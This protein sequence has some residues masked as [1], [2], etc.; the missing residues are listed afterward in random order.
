MSRMIDLIKQSKMPANMV[1]S[2]AKGALSVAP[3]EMIEILVYLAANPVF[4]Q[5]ARM[6]LAGW[7]EKT[8]KYVLED[9]R[10]PPDVLAYFSAPENIRLPLLSSLLDNPSLKDDLIVGLAMQASTRVLANMLWHPRVLSNKTTLHAISMNVNLPEEDAVVVRSALAN[11]GEDTDYLIEQARL[12]EE[13]AE[14]KIGDDVLDAELQRYTRE[15]ADEIAAEE[16][17]GKVFELYVEGTVPSLDFEAPAPAG[18]VLSGAGQVPSLVQKAVDAPPLAPDG[19]PDPSI[20]KK[21]T[22]FQKIA[23]LGV[24]GR[25]QLA[26][27]GSKDERFILVRD[28]SKVVSSAVLES[29]KI[30]DQEIEM[31]ATLKN[32]QEAVLRGISSKRKFM[33][34]YVVQKNLANNPRAPLD[35]TL[36]ILKGLMINDLRSMAGNKNINDTLRKMALKLYKQRTEKKQE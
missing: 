36:P 20:L 6:T 2:A 26:M 10:C 35:V 9:P 33:R 29:P 7:D 16:S 3:G 24:G 31:F 30:T 11:L 19:K 21:V 32:V 27:K 23:K 13:N 18:A 12:D 17:E 8:A 34:N 14:P 28:G 15:H 5:E 25:V 22:A 4:A 1:R